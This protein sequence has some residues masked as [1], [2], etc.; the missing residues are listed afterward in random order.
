MIKK[1]KG[2]TKLPISNIRRYSVYAIIGLIVLTV[3]LNFNSKSPFE[4]HKNI[5]IKDAQTLSLQSL[6][7]IAS[8]FVKINAI[9]KAYDTKFYNCLGQ[10]LYDKDESSTVDK[11]LGMCKQDYDLS[12]GK[13]KDYINTANIMVDFSPWDGSYRPLENS[14]KGNLK[15]PSSYEHVKTM[16][17]F[18]YYGTDRP[19]MNVKTVYRGKNSFGAI[20]TETT[21]IKVDAITKEVF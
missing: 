13:M 14:I 1:N 9:D 3:I 12:Q 5:T 6:K 8:D 7:N 15:D 2:D 4:Q 18:V 10:L 17:G 21:A 11:I 16:Y 20:V 19:Y